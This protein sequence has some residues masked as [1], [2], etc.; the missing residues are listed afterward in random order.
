MRSFFMEIFCEEIPAR[1]QSQAMEDLIKLFAQAFESRNIS[2][3]NSRAFVTPRRL[4]YVVD[5]DEQ[6]QARQEEKRGPKIGAPEQALQGFLKGSGVTLEEC[7]QENGYWFVRKTISAQSVKDLLPEIINNV[8]DGFSWPKSMRW[9][10][11]ERTWVRP[12]RQVLTLWG[13][14]HLSCHLQ[15][16]NMTST[17]QTYGHR[18]LSSQ[19]FVVHS[20]DDYQSKLRGAGVILDPQERYHQ[21]RQQLGHEAQKLKITW[22]EDESLLWEV[23]GLT[24]FPHVK[25]GRIDDAFMSVPAIVLMTSMKVHQRYFSFKNAD[26]SLAPYFAAVANTN[27]DAPEM[28]AGFEK[29]LKA[30]LSDAAFFWEQDQKT[31]LEDHGDRLCDIVFHAKLGTL[32]QKVERLGQLVTLPEAKR[33]A[34]LCKSDLLT[35][36][37]GEFPELQGQMGEIYARVQGESETVSKAIRAHYQPQGPQDACPQDLTSIE[38]AMADKVDTLMGFFAINE[39]PTGSRDPYGLRRAALG[40]IRLIRENDLKDFNLLSW[41]EK[42]AQLY[43]QQGVRVSEEAVEK[44]YDFILERLAVAMKAE[45]IRYDAVQSVTTPRQ[46]QGKTIW[47][48]VA[49]AQALNNFLES[50]D[51]Q[52]LFAAAR[53]IQRILEVGVSEGP[54]DSQLL[55]ESAEIALNNALVSLNAQLPTFLDQFDYVGAMKALSAVRIPVDT[56]FDEII[57]N[58]DDVNLRQNRQRMLRG[59]SDMFATLADFEKLEG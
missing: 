35:Q 7:T 6:T 37:V 3:Q 13:D 9:P 29:V 10:Q 58:A 49:R 47:S 36:M 14:T 51:G 34:F 31:P 23:V 26:G 53:R 46:R 59:L 45:G 55:C 12:I 43:I 27:S 15:S 8:M 19:P 40:M 57:V 20:F 32:A 54:V 56:F 24:E 39:P 2:F 11:A 52:A 48:M 42:A 30:R 18:F 16:L 1:M 5:L 28:M 41:L 50:A 44:A 38:L 25:V 21:I 4:A 33:A 22:V 17:H